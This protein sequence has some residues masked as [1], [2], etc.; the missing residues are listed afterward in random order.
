MKALHIIFVVT[1]FAGL[2]YM[3]RL[4]IYHVEALDQEEPKRNILT[5]QFK[6]MEKRLWYGITWPSAILTLFFGLAQIHQ[7]FP[8]RD[9]PWLML[10]LFFVILLFGY[11]HSVGAIFK[12]LKKNQCSYSSTWLRVYNEV[13]TLFLFAIVLLAVLKDTLDAGKLFG[14]L[15]LIS[16]VLFMSIRIYKKKR[17]QSTHS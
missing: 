5:A 10:K 17:E 8:L 14:L 3:V 12:K 7:F 6:I 16:L 11:H 13:A 1:W 9:H 4:F 15:I 2:F